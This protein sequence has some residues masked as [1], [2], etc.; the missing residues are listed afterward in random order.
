SKEPGKLYVAEKKDTY[1]TIS[2]KF[3]ISQKDLK[4]INGIKNEPLTEG[5]ELKVDKNGDY[6][7]YDAKFYTLEAGDDSYSKIAKKLNMKSGDLKKLNKDVDESTFHPGKR[8]RI[9]K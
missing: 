3:G 6:T 7:D 2:K 8:I 1:Q 5:M 4:A 9:S